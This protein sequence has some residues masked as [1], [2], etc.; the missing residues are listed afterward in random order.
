MG[1]VFRVALKRQ[2]N[3]NASRFAV[4]LKRLRD[5]NQS[6]VAINLGHCQ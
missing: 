4:V 1:V 3:S 6:G 5:L 2:L